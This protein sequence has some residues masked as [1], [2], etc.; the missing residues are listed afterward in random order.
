MHSRPMNV[1]PCCCFRIKASRNSLLLNRIT[2]PIPER[3]VTSIEIKP[4]SDRFTH[5]ILLRNEARGLGI[6][7]EA[8]VLAVIAVVAHEEEMT[9][10]HGPL[11]AGHAAAGEHDQVALLPQLLERGRNARVVVLALLG[12]AVGGA[13]R[14]GLQ[15]P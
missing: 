8:A 3:S 14:L 9:G 6:A 2:D 7:V 15:H 5:E 1:I 12:S 11:S 10:R 13:R 4:D